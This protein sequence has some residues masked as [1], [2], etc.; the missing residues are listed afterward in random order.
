MTSWLFWDVSQSR[1]VVTDVA[2]TAGPLKMRKI[3]CPETPVTNYPSTRR[4][5]PEER[6]S[7]QQFTLCLKLPFTLVHLQWTGD[8]RDI[9]WTQYPTQVLSIEEKVKVIFS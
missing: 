6:R 3:R 8:A 9:V 2:W 1:F 5:I 7:P 4:K